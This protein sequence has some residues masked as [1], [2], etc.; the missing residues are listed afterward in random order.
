MPQVSHHD[1]LLTSA[2]NTTVVAHGQ[3]RFILDTFEQPNLHVSVDNQDTC[4]INLLSGAFI[5]RPPPG[6]Y[7]DIMAAYR[8]NSQEIREI[9]ETIHGE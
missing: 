9:W 8:K 2:H 6:T 3:F 1:T 7:C 4:P 5:E